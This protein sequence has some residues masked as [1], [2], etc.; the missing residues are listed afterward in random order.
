MAP[1]QEQAA[2]RAA[3]PAATVQRF[4]GMLRAGDI[5]AA[6]E[7]LAEDVTYANVGM[8]TVRG[9]TRALRVLRAFLPRGSSFD[10]E[11]HA[12]ATAGST[13][14]TERTDVISRGRLR[15]AFWVCGRFDV[16]DGRIALWR[17]YFDYG[18]V[19]AGLLR[20]ALGAIRSR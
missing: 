3:D 20:G 4:L 14:L 12:I 9:R 2:E 6:G 8:I 11:I 7:L 1:V 13:V 19:A 18:N 10:V 5:D 15:V 17:D 16:E